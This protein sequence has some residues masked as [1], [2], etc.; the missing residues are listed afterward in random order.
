[1]KLIPNAGKVAKRAYSMWLIYGSLTLQ[2]ADQ[3]LPQLA[4]VLP[5]YV[6]ALVTAGAAVARLVKQ[7]DL[8]H[9]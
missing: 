3:V 2:V 1:M 6:P 5:W 9:G 4:G 8:H 7:E